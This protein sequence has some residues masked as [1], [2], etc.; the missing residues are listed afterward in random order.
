[1]LKHLRARMG[2][3]CFVLCITCLRKIETLV[4]KGME[5]VICV[6]EYFISVRFQ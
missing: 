4:F 2:G 5:T 1:M 6:S 3:E